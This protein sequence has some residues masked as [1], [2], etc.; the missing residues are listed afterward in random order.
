MVRYALPW[1]QRGSSRKICST[2]CSSSSTLGTF[3]I[4]HRRGF[5]N[6]SSSKGNKLS[7][8]FFR[9][10]NDWSSKKLARQRSDLRPLLAVQTRRWL[11]GSKRYRAR[12][13]AQGCSTCPRPILMV[14]QDHYDVCSGAAYAYATSADPA[15]VSSAN[16]P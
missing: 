2:A 8:S 7:L 9:L 11:S 10:T 5:R 15:P 12:L 13:T 1:D 16:S 4:R 3:G 6:I 14:A